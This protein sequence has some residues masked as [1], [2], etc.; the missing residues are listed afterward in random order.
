M[1]LGWINLGYDLAGGATG[2]VLFGP[3]GWYARKMAVLR[4]S[5]AA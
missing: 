2:L 4:A 5:A 3:E 1:D